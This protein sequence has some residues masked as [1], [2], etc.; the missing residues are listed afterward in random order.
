MPTLETG[1]MR[2]HYQIEG[3]TDAPC[4]VLSN[5]L[6]T[7]LDMWKPQM[8]SLLDHFRV[9][10]YDARGHGQSSVPP[11][12]YTVAQMG[13]DVLALMDHLNIKRAHFCG[14]S[15]GGL[16]GMWLAVKHPERIDRLVLCNTSALIGNNEMWEAR[17]E[18]VNKEGMAGIVQAVLSRWFTAD[19]IARVP[20]KVTLVR[21]MLMR[22]PAAGYVACCAA[23]RDM[24]LRDGIRTIKAP[25]LVIAGMRDKIT[26]PQEGKLVAERIAGARYA[27]LKA[28]HLSNWEVPQGFVTRII[29]FLT[30]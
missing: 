3:R 29:T 2:L 11:G 27:E 26:P 25:T 7:D 8:P 20:A 24:D 18:A 6:G 9:L 28:A 19:F 16:V 30:T 5:S 17:I 1:N 12:P 4:L 15:M 13:G 23:L 14:L 21:D 22:T 10:R